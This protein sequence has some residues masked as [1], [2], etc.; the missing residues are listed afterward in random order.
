L[1]RD[2]VVGEVGGHGVEKVISGEGRAKR[3]YVNG[4]LSNVFFAKRTLPDSSRARV[5]GHRQG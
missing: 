2:A 5:K 1:G 4:R 3:H